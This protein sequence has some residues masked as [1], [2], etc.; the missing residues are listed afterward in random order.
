MR[1]GRAEPREYLEK[2]PDVRRIIAE[3]DRTQVVIDI[4]SMEQVT[5]RSLAPWRFYVQIFGILSGLA[6]A[7][8]VVGIYGVM[9]YTV[10]RQTHEIGVRIALGAD[11]RD[12][13]ALILKHGLKLIVPGIALGLAG[14]LGL[15]RLIRTMLYGVPPADPLTFSIVSVV[16]MGV[17]LSACYFP[18]RRAMSVDPVKALRNE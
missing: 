11:S 4:R 14:A 12:V 10:S 8:A 18:A 2:N 7:L 5:A 6:T 16:L 9:S 1:C 15:T 3:A 13:L 17:A